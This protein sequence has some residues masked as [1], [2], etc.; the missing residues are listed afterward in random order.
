MNKELVQKK[1]NELIKGEQ[2]NSSIT[3]ELYWLYDTAIKESQIANTWGDW[4]EDHIKK[5]CK[6]IDALKAHTKVVAQST[7]V[8]KIASQSLAGLNEVE[9]QLRLVG[10]TLKQDQVRDKGGYSI[11]YSV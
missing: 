5:S 11:V 10:Q 9:N 6:A 7:A 2:D 1:K 3:K 8:A 4:L